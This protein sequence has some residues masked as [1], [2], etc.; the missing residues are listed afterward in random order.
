MRWRDGGG[1]YWKLRRRLDPTT[2]T[3]SKLHLHQHGHPCH[4]S[5]T[6]ESPEAMNLLDLPYP[7]FL[8]IIS[9]LSPPE[10]IRCKRIS[11]DVLRALTRHDLAISL[12]LT[13]FP[14]ARETRFLRGHLE[15]ENSTASDTADWAA[16]FST[17]AS[18]YY[19]LAA[20]LP[21]RITETTMLQDAER[22]RGVTPWNRFLRLD[23]KTAPFHYWDPMWTCCVQDSLLVYPG[24]NAVYLARDLQTGLETKVP[25]D[26]K[27]KVVRRVR[28]S[29]RI[30]VVEWCEEDAYHALND[31]DKAHR[32]FTTAFDV[33]VDGDL[34]IPQY[35]SQKAQRHIAISFRSEWRIHYLGLPLS[36]Q[37]RFF[38]THNSTHYVVYIW[39][40]TR[41]P[42]GEDEPLERL[43][44]WDLGKPSPYLPSLDPGESKRPDDDVGPRIVR[45]LVNGQLDAWGIRQHDTPSL[46]GLALDEGTW[47][48]HSCSSSG[49]VFFIEEEHRWSAGPHTR[50]TT[51]RL[52]HVKSTGV[53]LIGDG[54]RWVDECGGSNGTTMNFCW[55]G[56][57]RRAYS[58]LSGEEEWVGRAPCWRHDDFPYLT[59]CEAYDVAAGVRISARHCFMLE[60]LSVHMKP[61]LR[62]QGVD[63]VVDWSNSSS[64]SSSS[65]MSEKADKTLGGAGSRPKAR[66]S[67]DKARSS[68]GPEGR[69]IQFDDGLWSK[70][71]GNGVIVGDERWLIGEDGAGTITVLYF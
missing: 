1:L 6:H 37:D 49:H 66:K 44:I 5:G 8:E 70:L 53:P 27:G 24:T 60:T 63:T 61:R 33:V 48:V 22:L 43:I 55:R 13:H 68:D 31:V 29:H 2:W 9:Y 58:S 67:K 12:L 64:S 23:D 35:G 40:P 45:K 51:P 69:E 57:F 30:L 25:F 18:R 14:R 46:R 17:L 71:M 42:W 4:R 52:H 10:I 59:V 47:D 19:H 39:Q 3:T 50:Q 32:H 16:V 11:K 41:S 20:A 34:S 21:A 26:L 62:I 36:H 28:L 56:A 7:V 38:S 65:A 54:P 15:D